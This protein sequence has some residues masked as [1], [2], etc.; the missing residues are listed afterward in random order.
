MKALLKYEKGSG[1]FELRDVSIPEPGENEV[2]EEIEYAGICGTDV[3]ILHDT[4][5]DEPPMIVGHEFSG[6]IV[7]CGTGANRF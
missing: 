7:K 6:R 2:L 4:Y 1:K 5:E 3:H